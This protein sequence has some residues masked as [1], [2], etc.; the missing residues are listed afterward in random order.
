MDREP[1]EATVTGITRVRATDLLCA[2]NVTGYKLPLKK[3]RKYALISIVQ[4]LLLASRKKYCR[5][6]RDCMSLRTTFLTINQVLY[7][8]IIII[9][10]LIS[11]HENYFRV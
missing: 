10:I 7:S 11:L 9:K 3:L 1:G 5:F 2:V 8:K 4:N 6:K